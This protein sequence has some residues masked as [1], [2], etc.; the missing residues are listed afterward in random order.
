MTAGWLIRDISEMIY[1]VSNV[2]K[3]RDCISNTPF[4]GKLFSLTVRVSHG[5]LMTVSERSSLLGKE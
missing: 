1:Q 3:L 4:A 5:N 2:S